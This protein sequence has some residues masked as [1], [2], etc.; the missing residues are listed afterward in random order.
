MATNATCGLNKLPK[1]KTHPLTYQEKLNNILERY[2]NHLHIFTE[3]SKSNNGI[4]CGTVLHKK[5]LKKS[6]SKEASIF[7][8]EI[9]AIDFALKLVSTSN[10]EKFIIHSDSISVL[11]SLKNTKLDY[12]FIVNLLN[13]LNSV[14]HSEKVIFCWIPSHIAIQ[15]ND[16]VDSL[17]KTAL[18]MVPDK[19]SKIPYTSRKSGK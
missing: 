16:K 10:K 14:N 6:F 19:K 9:W 8:A 1:N 7:S 17:A 11:K 15:G 4:G 18:N 5:T 2:P 13:E 12:P 3:G